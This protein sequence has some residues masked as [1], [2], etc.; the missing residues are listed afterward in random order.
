MRRRSCLVCTGLARAS[1]GSASAWVA[2]CRQPASCSG[3]K[4][5]ARHHALLAASSI[6][7]VVSTASNRAAAV[8]ARSR[9]GLDSSSLRQRSSVPVPIATSRATSSNA[10]LSGGNNLATA[11]LLN[12]CP[13]LAKSL[14]HRCPM[15]VGSIGV[16][17]ILT[18]GGSATPL[19]ARPPSSSARKRACSSRRLCD[20]SDTRDALT[21]RRA[22][23]VAAYRFHLFLSMAAN[24][25]LPPSVGFM[26]RRAPRARPFSNLL[27]GISP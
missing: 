1:V 23:T 19:K 25:G 26:Q 4:P 24:G 3:N 27:Q 21:W 22:A 17:G 5:L 7:A 13:Y 10:A 14:S 6:T 18:R 9:A 12:A 20:R 11:L 8:Q 2:L 15:F 16:T